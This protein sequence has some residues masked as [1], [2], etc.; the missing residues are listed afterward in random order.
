MKYNDFIRF[1]KENGIPD[2]A[3]SLHGL[4]GNGKHGTVYDDRLVLQRFGVLWAVYYF[5]KG[6]KDSVKLHFAYT[7]ALD[8]LAARLLVD[9]G[10]W[11]RRIK[12]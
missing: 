6:T 8:D 9:A 1:I 10:Y 5:E 11:R 2:A 4:A 7:K 12:R 3:Y